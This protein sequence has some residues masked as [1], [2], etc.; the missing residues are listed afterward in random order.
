MTA[1]RL[2]GYQVKRLDQLIESAF[3]QAIAEIGMTRREWQ[4]LNTI[5]R[6]P[7]ADL[8]DALRPWE[9]GDESVT[10]V[11]AALVGRGWIVPDADGGHTATDLG[12]AAHERAA[13]AVDVVRRRMTDGITPAEFTAFTE[14]LGRLIG[15]LEPVG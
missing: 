6:T 12:R 1:R 4:T 11:T 13:R 10:E 9:S 5:V 2:I 3:D 8:R 15:N 7:A 14:T